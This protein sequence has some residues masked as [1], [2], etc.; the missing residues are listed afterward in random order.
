MDDEDNDTDDADEDEESSSGTVAKEAHA[1]VDEVSQM[2]SNV[3][4]NPSP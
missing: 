1:A 4:F 3:K 2:L